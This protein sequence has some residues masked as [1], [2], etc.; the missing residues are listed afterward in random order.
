[1]KTYKISLSKLVEFVTTIEVKAESE[2]EA[3]EEALFEEVADEDWEE[4]GLWEPQTVTHVN[5]K[6]LT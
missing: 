2:E 6:I 4:I 3:R 1:M 5:G